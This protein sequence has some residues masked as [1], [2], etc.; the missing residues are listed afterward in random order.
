MDDTVIQTLK[1]KDTIDT[2]RFLA[3]IDMIRAHVIRDG[4]IQEA[5]ENINITF[6]SLDTLHGVMPSTNRSFTYSLIEQ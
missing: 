6:E 4:F 3:M 2:E 1:E 5:K